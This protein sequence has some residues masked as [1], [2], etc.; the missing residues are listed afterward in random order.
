MASLAS[1]F[2]Q[3]WEVKK[4]GNRGVSYHAGQSGGERSRLFLILIF[5]SWLL[6]FESVVVGRGKPT[7]HILWSKVYK[8][9]FHCVEVHSPRGRL[10]LLDT[11]RGVLRA[12]VSLYGCANRN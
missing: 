3:E 10:G 7:K 8:T 9:V 1:I 11:S 2:V 12:C 5:F 6:F 4:K